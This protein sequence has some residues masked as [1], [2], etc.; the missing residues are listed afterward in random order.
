M[1]LF[2]TLG[3][4]TKPVVRP[5]NVIAQEIVKDWNKVN[6]GAKPYLTAMLTLN[7]IKDKYIM[8][9]GKSIVLYFLSNAGTWKGTKAREIK[10]ELKTLCK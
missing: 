6:F 8:D 7:S 3:N 2:E 5:L 1:D 4:A 9:S 10:A